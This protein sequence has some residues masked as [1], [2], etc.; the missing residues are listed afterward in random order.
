MPL[1]KRMKLPL[2]WDAHVCVVSLASMH[3]HTE[4]MR[5]YVINA[6]DEQHTIG[7]R[8]ILIRASNTHIVVTNHTHAHIHTLT[9]SYFGGLHAV[10]SWHIQMKALAPLGM[11]TDLKW[12]IWSTGCLHLL[13]LLVFFGLLFFCGASTTL[14]TPPI[15]WHPCINKK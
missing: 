10:Q 3:Y 13:I 14:R 5:Y 15:S 9:C 12:C 4:Q 8:K 11:L 1:S 7:Y 6:I 2:R